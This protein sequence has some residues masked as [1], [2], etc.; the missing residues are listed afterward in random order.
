MDLDD[1][2]AL[3]LAIAEVLREEAL[4]HALYGGLLLAAY[5]EAHETRDVDLA[6][7]QAGAG[8]LP[9]TLAARL[10][11]STITAFRL[12]LLAPAR[13][14]RHPG[15]GDHLR[16]IVSNIPTSETTA[17]EREIERLES[18]ISECECSGL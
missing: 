18:F 5:G 7:A 4:P 13:R 3:A 1:P 15:P 16:D 11:V 12:R 6:V 9:R 17:G 2:I 10:G 8:T 14:A